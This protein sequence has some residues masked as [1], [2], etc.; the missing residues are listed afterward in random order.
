MKNL[1]SV[2]LA[3][4]SSRA[5][6]DGYS[7][8]AQ[9][10][11]MRAYCTNNELQLVK[12]F[13]IA[14]TASKDEQRKVFKEM[15][16]E[17]QQDKISHLIV[18]KTDRLTRNF[19]DAVIIDDW[20]EQNEYRRLHMVKESLIIHKHAKSDAKL[21]WDIYLAFAKKY[22]D[23]LREEA[24]KGWDEK[25]AQGWMPAPPP[26]GYKNFTE[27]G[28]K[29]H[30]IDDDSA[31]MIKRAF[32]Y[33]LQ[34]EGCVRTVT[35]ELKLCGLTTRN[36]RA[37]AKSSVHRILSNK[38][39]I[40]VI[41]FSGSEYPGAHEPLISVEL[42]NEVQ[43]KL[44]RNTRPRTRTSDFLLKGL[45]RCKSCNGLVTWQKQKGW[46]YGGCQRRIDECK[47]R[48]LREDR[49][50]MAIL[51]NL[52]EVHDD[53]DLLLDELKQKLLERRSPFSD[54]NLEEVQTLL[55]SQLSRITVMQDNLFED[56]LQNVVSQ[57]VYLKKTKQL[58]ERTDK[59]EKRL[60]ELSKC[61]SKLNQIVI[62]KSK[63]ALKNLYVN[64]DKID[65][66]I[67]IDRLF[68]ITTYKGEVNIAR[69]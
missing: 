65:K 40:G 58:S 60:G 54:G 34:P 28:R 8:D 69:T 14:E 41:Q 56:K 33:F 11:L 24:M 43:T 57:D 36:N 48:F 39:Y 13:R 4:V 26:A 61:R 62:Q 63:Y 42:F 2:T 35:E 16:K 1:R 53:E 10:K 22:T 30:V 18:E 64:S 17:I 44:K 9:S 55:G 31:F 67:I 23:N 46:V 21:M 49:V 50:E 38:F 25:L 32:K 51:M 37:Y 12:E 52:E 3:R 47:N 7:L 5:Q 20:L 68:T 6:E 15:L 27:N 45:I 59:I 19:R 29:I 66:R